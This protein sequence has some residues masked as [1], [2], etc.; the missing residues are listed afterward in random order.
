MDK[1]ITIIVKTAGY[2]IVEIF[3]PDGKSIWLLVLSFQPAESNSA[4]STDHCG[5]TGYLITGFMKHNSAETDITTIVTNLERHLKL[6]KEEKITLK[7]ANRNWYL[8][9]YN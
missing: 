6:L 5:F 4:I 3:K 2:N 9:G 8:Y 1:L 7:I